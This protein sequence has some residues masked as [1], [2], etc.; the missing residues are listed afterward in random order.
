MDTML[1]MAGTGFDCF[2]LYLLTE[3]DF[4]H[5]QMKREILKTLYSTRAIK[6]IVF[7]LKS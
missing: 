7:A 3:N 5:L 4:T 2:I 6:S 1:G